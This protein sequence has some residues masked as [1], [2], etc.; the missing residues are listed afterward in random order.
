[1]E[2]KRLTKTNVGLPEQ[3]FS[4]RGSYGSARGSVEKFK[5]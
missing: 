3:R 1:M 2:Y 5:M 4:N